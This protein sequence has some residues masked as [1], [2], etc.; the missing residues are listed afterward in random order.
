MDILLQINL[1]LSIIIE[2]EVVMVEEE[3]EEAILTIEEVE[4]EVLL[5]DMDRIGHRLTNEQTDRMT[6][7]RRRRLQ[8]RLQRL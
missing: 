2:G 5:M 3:V 4:A 8:L 1:G 6:T 7:V